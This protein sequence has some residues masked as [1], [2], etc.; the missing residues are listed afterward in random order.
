MAVSPIATS[1]QH[2]APSIYSSSY[3]RYKEDT[4]VF[5]TWL[6]N[7]AKSCGYVVKADETTAPQAAP[8]HAHTSGPPKATRLK[9][10]ERKLAKQA[11]TVAPDSKNASSTSPPQKKYKISVSELL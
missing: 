9:G 7:A 11:A 3:Q 1:Q 5:T 6:S 4:S 8:S 2:M 10:K